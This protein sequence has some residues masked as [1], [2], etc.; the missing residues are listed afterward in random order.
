MAYCD[1]QEGRGMDKIPLPSVISEISKY[2][3]ATLQLLSNSG[4]NVL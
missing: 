3:L 1:K 4:A 2:V